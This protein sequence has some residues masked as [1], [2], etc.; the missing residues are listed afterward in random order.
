[1]NI[2][3]KIA[4]LFGRCQHAHTALALAQQH[5]AV[6]SKIILDGLHIGDNGIARHVHGVRQALHRAKSA[7]RKGEQ[8]ACNKILTLVKRKAIVIQIHGVEQ[9]VQTGNIRTH[10]KANM[11]RGHLDHR[12]AARVLC[13]RGG[14]GNI[15]PQRFLGYAVVIHKRRKPQTVA[16]RLNQAT[17]NLR[18]ALFHLTCLP[19]HKLARAEGPVR[20]STITA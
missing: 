5:D 1:M 17:E 7:V 2:D 10:R 13:K 8:G 15:C 18:A 12:V 3:K 9:L 20:K 19:A 14:S 16:R 11:L 4:P 6:P